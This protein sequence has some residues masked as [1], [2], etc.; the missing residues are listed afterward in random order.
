MKIKPLLY[1]NIQ[2]THTSYA[3]NFEIENNITFIKGDS[4]TGK[5]AVFSFIEELTTEKKNIKC[6]NYL[7]AKANYKVAIKRS[8]DKLFVID[9][10]D[11]LLDDKMREYIAHDKNNQYIIIGRNPKGLLLSYDEIYELKSSTKGEITSFSL[12]QMKL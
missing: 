12:E 1:S 7:D 2:T 8:K 6:Y 10:A 9:N 11:L 4:G 5:S 3:V